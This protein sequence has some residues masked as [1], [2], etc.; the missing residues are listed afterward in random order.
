MALLNI[1]TVL[2]AA[3]SQP[4]LRGA[5]APP[6]APSRLVDRCGVNGSGDYATPKTLQFYRNLLSNATTGAG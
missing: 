4:G 1:L 6:L 5:S 2:V 3:S